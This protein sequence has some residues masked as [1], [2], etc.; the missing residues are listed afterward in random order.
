VP[1][2][3]LS[4]ENPSDGLRIIGLE[5]E[6][7]RSAPMVLTHIPEAAWTVEQLAPSR[8]ALFECAPMLHVRDVLTRVLD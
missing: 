3:T 7:D 2:P 4:K 8:L 5:G 6:R 1:L